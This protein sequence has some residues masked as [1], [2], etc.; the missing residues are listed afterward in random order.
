MHD[1]V[2]K[3]A[4][5]ADGLGNP[6]VE[7]DLAVKDGRVAAIGR[8]NDE[9]AETVDA[10][11]LVLAP[12]CVDVH[13]HYDAQ[14]T[15]DMTCSPSPALGV[16][17]VVVGNCGFGIAP[18]P[19][20]RRETVMK[21]LA[22]VEAMPLEALQEGIDWSFE[23]FGEYLDLLARKSVYPNVATLASHTTMRTAVMGDAGSERPSTPDEQRQLIA[24]FRDAMASG[25]AG[26]GSSTNENHRAFGG[27]PIASRMASEDEFRALVKV[28]ADYRH[29]LFMATCGHHTGID[30]LAELA[31]ISGKPALYA[32]LVA[33]S[34]APER[35]PK[36]MAECD[37]ARARGLP[38]YAQTSCQPVSLSFALTS[39]YI[40]K[41]VHPW[42]SSED[43]AALKPIFAD[44]AFRQAIRDTLSKPDPR[45]VFNGRWDLMDVTTVALARNARH[46]GRTIAEIAAQQGR[47]PV[48]VFLDFGLEEELKTIFTG[49]IL[50]VEEDRVAELLLNDGVLVSL[51][52]AGAHNTFLCDAAYAMHFFGRWVREKRLFD[53]PTAVRKVTSDPAEVYGII[54]R[55]RLTRGAF[56]DMILFD[57]DTIAAGKLERH[58]DMPAGGERLLRRASGLKGTW[59]NG[60]QVFDGEDYVR[61]ARGPGHVLRKF[62]DAKPRLGMPEAKHAAE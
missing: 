27:L 34:N 4:R 38:V 31:R 61:L 54:D 3:N 1:L 2:I 24:L 18:T 43:P 15:W 20:H 21:N 49:R 36:L 45:R 48:D 59:V 58:R 55:G 22:E 32:P 42:P 40:L 11:G 52:D 41:T 16:T 17:T 47:D 9:A 60:V 30:F 33:Y 8:I 37:A 39:A 50:N 25:A 56:A 62:A 23:S 46:E 5:I 57:P 44:P 26:L 12:G 14:L 19:P 13:T 28:M 35:A 7:G 10:K 29:G 6:L 51:S 53:L